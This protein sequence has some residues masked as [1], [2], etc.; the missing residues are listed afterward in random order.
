[1][2]NIPLQGTPGVF[3][4]RNPTL[5]P[6]F[7]QAVASDDNGSGVPTVAL[8][9]P[10]SVLGANP[11][12][13][14]SAAVTVGGS[15]STNDVVE[16]TFTHPEIAGGAETVKLKVTASMTTIEQIAEALA[17]AINNDAELGFFGV[18][19]TVAADVITVDWGG[20]VGN[21]CVLSK[22]NGS[23]A[24]LTLNPV[25]GKLSGGTGPVIAYNNFQFHYNGS[26]LTFWAGKPYPG[27]APDLVG[28]LVAQGQP[29]V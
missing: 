2:P 25:T 10:A 21:S 16:L 9:S 29:I 22:V 1:M 11:R 23:D 28:A 5:T 3:D 26:T 18:E 24:T 12:A 6:N 27:L 19:A 8:L 20:P 14:A 15:A 7:D 17:D 13:A 4:F